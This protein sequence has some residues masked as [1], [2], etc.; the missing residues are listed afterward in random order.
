MV[1]E[2]A[3]LVRD[4]EKNGRVSA[5]AGNNDDYC[6]AVALALVNREYASAYNFNLGNPGPGQEVGIY[7]RNTR[8][9][10][11]WE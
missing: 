2:M 10:W 4:P 5:S 9:T 6:T 8:R 7:P 11:K 3:G 1:D